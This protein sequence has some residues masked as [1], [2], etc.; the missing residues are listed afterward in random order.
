MAAQTG[1][2]R[3]LACSLKKCIQDPL[4]EHMARVEVVTFETSREER[5]H[6]QVAWIDGRAAVFHDICWKAVVDSCKM[7]NPFSLCPLEKDMVAEARK[8]AEYF[9]SAERLRLEAKRISA[10]LKTAQYA[11]AFT[12]AG[13]STSAGIGDFRGKNGKWTEM[14]RAKAR[15]LSCHCDCPAFSYEALRPTYTHEAIC[16]LV[17]LGYLKHVISQNTDGLHRLSG[18]P[19]EQ[20]SELHGRHDMFSFGLTY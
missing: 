12:G 20:L 7:D 10:M 5:A 2:P 8:T 16:K 14:D 3:V 17:Q 13:I 19:V 9:D 6:M 18:I 11:S 4:D 15:G 1:R